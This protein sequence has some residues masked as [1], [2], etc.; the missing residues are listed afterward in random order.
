MI[1]FSYLFGP[2]CA[3]SMASG[4]VSKTRIVSYVS[5]CINSPG[6]LHVAMSLFYLKSAPQGRNIDS[7]VMVV[8]IF[9]TFVF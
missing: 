4:T 2:T 8:V 3:S 6:M 5:S 7:V 9:S 1:Y